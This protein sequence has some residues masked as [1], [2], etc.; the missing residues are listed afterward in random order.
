MLFREA[1]CEEAQTLE[2]FYTH[3]L[4]LAAK[5]FAEETADTVDRMITDQF[6]VGCEV[7]RTSL[8][9]I[10][11]GSHTS[12]EAL[13]FGI[14]HQA[15]I[16]YYESLK[17]TSAV[18][19]VGYQLPV[20]TTTSQK[21]SETWNVNYI[22]QGCD[23]WNGNQENYYNYQNYQQPNYRQQYQLSAPNSGPWY[24]NNSHTYGRNYQGQRRG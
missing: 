9:L 19:A 14:A 8:Q 12:R 5:A 1:K 21:F 7:D 3:L 17:D 10:E 11:K 24:P 4:G 15:A 2:V 6:I 16:R 23:Q 13:A 20:M 18:A 22:Q